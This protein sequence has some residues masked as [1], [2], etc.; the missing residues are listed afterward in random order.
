MLL[1]ILALLVSLILFL[2][3]LLQLHVHCVLLVSIAPI[4][5]WM[6][7]LETATLV[8]TA[9]EDRYWQRMIKLLQDLQRLEVDAQ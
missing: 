6:P 8:T 2:D 4:P 1:P 3:K 5:Q 7:L 9:Q